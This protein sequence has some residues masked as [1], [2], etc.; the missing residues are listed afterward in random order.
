MA[1]KLDARAVVREAKESGL[2]VRIIPEEGF[3]FSQ[4]IHPLE[5]I[6]FE[7]GFWDYHFGRENIRSEDAYEINLRQIKLK[8]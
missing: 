8:Y 2:P 5:N 1:I 7:E 3:N 6:L 4:H